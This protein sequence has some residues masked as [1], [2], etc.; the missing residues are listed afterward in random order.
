MA[1]DTVRIR[2]GIYQRGRDQ[3]AVYLDR[4]GLGLASLVDRDEVVLDVKGAFIRGFVRTA[5]NNCWLGTQGL[6]PTRSYRDNLDALRVV[7]VTRKA[8]PAWEVASIV[9]RNGVVVPVADPELLQRRVAAINSIGVANF[10]PVGNRVPKK[11]ERT[12]VEYQRDPAV[13]ARVLQ[14]ADGRCELCD[15]PAPFQREDGSPFLEVH[16]AVTLANGGS[17]TE[18]NAVALCPNC[19]RLMHHAGEL[20]RLSAVKRLR[21][22]VARLAAN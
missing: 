2:V 4:D 14:L 22:T 20:D 7:G 9:A 21:A 15:K 8:E 12:V 3:D 5:G 6:K 17:D 13:V 10:S 16:H 11:V 1:A 18:D 19:H